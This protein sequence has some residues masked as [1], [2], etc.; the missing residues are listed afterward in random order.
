MAFCVVSLS[1]NFVADYAASKLWVTQKN[2]ISLFVKLMTIVVTLLF[3]LSCLLFLS[4][5]NNISALVT[6]NTSKIISAHDQIH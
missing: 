1:R 3:S 5:F 6:T 2:F 4:N